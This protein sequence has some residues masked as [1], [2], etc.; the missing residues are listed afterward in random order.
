MTFSR[1]LILGAKIQI[2]EISLNIVNCDTTKKIW[3]IWIS[4]TFLS[5][6]T[7]QK[8]REI[9]NWQINIRREIQII[10]I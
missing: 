7:C 10:L 4:R 9:A 5:F 6:F 3:V 1:Q 2:F 8:V